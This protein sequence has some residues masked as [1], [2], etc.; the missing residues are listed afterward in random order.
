[1]DPKLKYPLP[2]GI[3]RHTLKV[4]QTARW[5][6]IGTSPDSCRKIVIALHGYGQHPAYMLDG[7]KPLSQEELCIA[8]PEGLSRFYI[9]G[10]DGRVG[11]SWMT[12]D[13]RLSDIEDHISYL[14]HWWSSLGVPSDAE[15]VVLGFSQGVATAAR[16]L[17]DGFAAD[18]VI[19]HSGTIPP[20][21]HHIAP[22]FNEKITKWISIRGEDDKIYPKENHEEAATLF[23][24]IGLNFEY[25]TVKGGH[26]MNTED[27]EQYLKLK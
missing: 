24:S 17:A 5:F 10:T 14:N 7:L 20:E 2:D 3:S 19:F 1:M 21:W 26:K 9:R 12:R 18:L 8:A 16:W 23:G 15:I 11:A 6:H 22:T 25:L 4:E 13:E 27:L